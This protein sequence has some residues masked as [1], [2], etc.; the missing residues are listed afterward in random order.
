[1]LRAVLRND[2]P[3]RAACAAGDSPT[4]ASQG[5]Q[6]RLLAAPATSGSRI[7]CVAWTHY[8]ALIAIATRGPAGSDV[9]SRDWRPN[10]IAIPGL[11]CRLGTA[12]QSSADIINHVQT[13]R[14]WWLAASSGVWVDLGYKAAR[15]QT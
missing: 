8:Y 10:T 5:A 2:N 11:P 13:S 14:Q 7:E 12:E 1:M 9:V 4:I 3:H 15:C 6:I